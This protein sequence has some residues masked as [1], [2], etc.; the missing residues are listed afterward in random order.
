MDIIPNV[1]QQIIIQ[2]STNYI[3]YPLFQEISLLQAADEITEVEACQLREMV[4]R[5][6]NQ[7]QEALRQHSLYGELLHSR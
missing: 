7:V 4:T 2:S 6:D 3:S 5:G 1:E